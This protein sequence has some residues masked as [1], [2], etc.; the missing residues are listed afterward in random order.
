MLIIFDTRKVVTNAL[1]KRIPTY[2]KQVMRYVNLVRQQDGAVCL[3][4]EN[5]LCSFKIYIA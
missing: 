5:I 3:I 4:A 1:T 2:S